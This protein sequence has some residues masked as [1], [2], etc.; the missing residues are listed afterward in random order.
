MGRRIRNE[1]SSALIYCLLFLTWLPKKSMPTRSCCVC[2]QVLNWA[3]W[4]ISTTP[5]W[6]EISK[7]VRLRVISCNFRW[8]TVWICPFELNTPGSLHRHWKR[9]I[10]VYGDLCYLFQTFIVGWNKFCSRNRDGLNVAKYKHRGFLLTSV[11]CE[12]SPITAELIPHHFNWW[13]FVVK[14][15][16]ENTLIIEISNFNNYTTTL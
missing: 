5:V 7:I 3:Y 13:H 6:K 12:S 2:V 14:F 11:F 1:H 9:I 4:T 8:L 10:T 15:G 16:Y